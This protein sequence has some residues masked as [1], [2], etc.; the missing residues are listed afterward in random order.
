ML[1]VFPADEP[2]IQLSSTTIGLPSEHNLCISHLS[3]PTT[4]YTTLHLISKGG[5]RFTSVSPHASRDGQLPFLVEDMRQ[6]AEIK[7]SIRSKKMMGEFIKAG[8]SDSDAIVFDHLT[9]SLANRDSTERKIILEEIERHYSVYEWW[10]D[11]PGVIDY[12]IA[13]HVLNTSENKGH[14]K[15]MVEK[16][17][18]PLEGYL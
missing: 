4:L 1:K 9:T 16:V 2:V 17:I 5:V 12:I 13:A 11:K 6:G 8:L 3:D 15:K 7:R 10:S 18:L 14:I